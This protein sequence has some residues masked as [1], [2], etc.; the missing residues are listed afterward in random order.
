[1]PELGNHILMHLPTKKIHY[2]NP[3]V[4]YDSVK[5]SKREFKILQYIIVYVVHKLYFKFKFWKNK[6]CV[7]S[8]QCLSILLCYKINSD[9]TQTL[10]DAKD[11]NWLWRVNETVPNI[12]IDC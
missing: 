11:W 8:K 6:D 2:D 12:F 9:D 7:Y 3:T 1:M 10:I 5:L 4:K